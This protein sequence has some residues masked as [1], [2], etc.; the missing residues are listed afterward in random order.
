M[1]A[2][3][4]AAWLREF[5]LKDRAPESFF[6][7]IA[8]LEALG[9]NAPQPH[10]IRR[11]FER[12]ELNGVLCKEKIPLV[13]FRLVDSIDPSEIADLHRLFWNQGVAPI[14]VI[15]APTEVHVYSGLIQ[16][17][18]HNDS[19]AYTEAACRKTTSCVPEIL[20]RFLLAVETGEYFHTHRKSFD[21]QQRV[22]R[23][24]LRDL[25]ATRERLDTVPSP[26][27]ESHT[28]SGLLCR[29]VFTCYLF[30]RDI[31][32]AKYLSEEAD[33]KDASHLRDILDRKPRSQAKSDLY[34]LFSQLLQKLQR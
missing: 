27:I 22:D 8:A 15:I 24:L 30:D 19:S 16:P 13:Y 33:I 5:R 11:A 9:P 18:N 2:K 31:I 1:A 34:R 7:D 20:Q 26:R 6:T 29:L 23:N 28:L 14:L 3:H 4:T 21:P 17:T 10:A 25:K 12:L 32:D